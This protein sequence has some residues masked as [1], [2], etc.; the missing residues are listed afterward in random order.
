MAEAN[1]LL[2]E[3]VR[4]TSQWSG[5]YGKLFTPQ[6]RQQFPSNRE[7]FRSSGERLVRLLNESSKL[8]EEAAG[9]MDQAARLVSS[10]NEK[11][12]LTVLTA[13]IRKS[14]EINNLFK[15]QALLASDLGIKDQKIFNEKFLNL[16]SFIQ[17]KSKE[18][19]DQQAEG[20]K[21]LGW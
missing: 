17:Q 10:D 16:M 20:K 21:L 8:N 12:G 19:D 2:K 15:E 13:S 5:E 14:I 4:V 7:S 11:K 9:K 18:R 3:D 6:N 1:K